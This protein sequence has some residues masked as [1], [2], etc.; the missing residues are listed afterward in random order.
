MCFMMKLIRMLIVDLIFA[1]DDLENNVACARNNLE[2]DSAHAE[3]RLEDDSANA[4]VNPE[5]QSACEGVPLAS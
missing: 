2:E 4:N 5:V 1:N 3:N